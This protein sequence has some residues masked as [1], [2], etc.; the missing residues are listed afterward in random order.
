M[1]VKVCAPFRLVETKKDESDVPWAIKS[2]PLNLLI[3]VNVDPD[4][5]KESEDW[6]NLRS[7]DGKWEQHKRIKD[8]MTPGDKFVDLLFTGLDP[9]LSYS[10][11]ID[12]RPHGEKHFLFENRPF[13]ELAKVSE[14]SDEPQP[15]AGKGDLLVRIP[16][17]PADAREAGA[18]FVLK[19]K[20][21]YEQKKSLKDDLKA[22]DKAVD[23]LFTAIPESD[24]LTLEVHDGKG[25]HKVFE[26]TLYAELAHLS[27]P[28]G[29]ALPNHEMADDHNKPPDGVNLE[30]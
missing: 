12:P 11:E 30:G 2:T 7:T 19:G 22:G 24:S 25:E 3:R 13:A 6:F 8:D 17:D 29:S 18:T 26:D 4:D 23:L 9:E 1:P 21:G 16:M 27:G 20:S 28:D 10:L 5:A 15:E 14:K